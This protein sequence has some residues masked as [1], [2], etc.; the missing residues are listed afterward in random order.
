MKNFNFIFIIILLFNSFIIPLVTN[1][2]K[3]SDIS[4]DELNQ[5]ILIKSNQIINS[6]NEKIIEGENSKIKILDY[7]YDAI[8]E[9]PINQ[10]K[11]ILTYIN[12][13]KKGESLSYEFYNAYD[14]S[15]LGYGYINSN[16]GY[17]LKSVPNTKL[18]TKLKLI[19]KKDLEVFVKYIGLNSYYQPNIEEIKLYYDKDKK[20]L[21]WTQPIENEEFRY[22]IYI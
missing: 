5:N 12:I 21:S 14:G 19:G 18:G 7:S 3:N 9:A 22:D 2:N 11:Y 10:T 1:L 4:K 8:L 20:K 17:G 6:T 15:Y 16:I 13:C